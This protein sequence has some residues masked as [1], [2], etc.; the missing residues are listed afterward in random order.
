MRRH[1]LC[2]LFTTLFT[3]IAFVSSASAATITVNTNDDA[4]IADGNCSIR[5][6]FASANQD[7]GFDA[8]T[9]GNG[10]DVIELLGG[11][12]DLEV[13]PMAA[14]ET[15]DVSDDSS[16][17]P[18][19][20]NICGD[21]VLTDN[22]IVNGN[23][24]IV[25]SNIPA[26]VLRID[27]G[28]L[29]PTAQ[30]ENADIPEDDFNCQAPIAVTLNN[31]TIQNGKNVCEGAG[32]ANYSAELTLNDMNVI[33]NSV[34][35]YY[36]RGGGIYSLWDLTANNS[37]ISGNGGYHAYGGGIYIEAEEYCINDR[38]KDG[39]LAAGVSSVDPIFVKLTLNNTDVDNNCLEGSGD[40]EMASTSNESSYDSCAYGG[41]I[42][43]H[44]ANASITNGSSV[45]GNEALYSGAGI[46]FYYGNLTIDGS[47]V[48]KNTVGRSYYYG[49]GAGI[50]YYGYGE[51]EFYDR[52]RTCD[53]DDEF[54][55]EA[56][57]EVGPLPERKLVINNS[58]V[59][60][61][62]AQDRAGAIEAGMGDLEINNSTIDNNTAGY[63]T[64]GIQFEG[65]FDNCTGEFVGR[66]SL[67]G[68]TVSNNQSP[69]D[70]GISNSGG[71]FS[72]ENSTISTNTALLSGGGGYSQGAGLRIRRAAEG[73]QEATGDPD[74][75]AKLSLGQ[76]IED[77][78]FNPA[79]FADVVF[80]T[81]NNCTVYNN[82][83][84]TVDM[85]E[86]PIMM[87]MM[88]AVT[89]VTSLIV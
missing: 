74:A 3:L 66:F 70:G 57:L 37:N 2:C 69:F 36:C 64:G 52:M 8:C 53:G 35:S 72:C 50:S 58:T 60:A 21:L 61:N 79:D 17:S 55:P 43:A 14:S 88:M 86:S 38:I 85:V 84:E 7:F 73:L 25:N 51:G 68:S 1:N 48:D 27:T 89:R 44:G 76:I 40:L 26:R 9:A 83:V 67:I 20:P 45:S 41:G 4:F 46:E 81:F 11:Q 49:S 5:E 16:P 30:T 54:T 42:Y 28:A 71:L 18:Y 29:M 39:A 6:A 47:N 62:S 56:N 23:G 80:A 34:N 19:S 12:I 87:T 32:I 75:K 15:A 22:T 13:C 77:D 63:N 33:D 78:I 24:T 10:D 31:F 65:T 59:N 82:S